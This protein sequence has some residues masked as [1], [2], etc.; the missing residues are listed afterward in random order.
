MSSL[1]HS[2][3]LACLF[4]LLCCASNS[5]SA[6]I[7]IVDAAGSG[8]FLDLPPALLVVQPGDL[9][10]VE[11]GDYSGGL[12]PCAITLRGRGA[13]TRIRGALRA[14]GLSGSGILLI[15]SLTLA[16]VPQRS[17]QI[18]AQACSIYSY[19]YEYPE[20]GLRFINCQTPIHVSEVHAETFPPDGHLNVAGGMSLFAQNCAELVLVSSTFRCL[21]GLGVSSTG[22][23]NPIYNLNPQPVVDAAQIERCRA[24]VDR[25][26]FEG[27]PGVRSSGYCN[28]WTLEFSSTPG[29]RGG[30]GLRIAASRVLLNASACYG[31][32]GADNHSIFGPYLCLTPC[33]RPTDGGNGV[34]ILDGIYRRTDLLAFA[35]A[36]RGGLGGR[37]INFDNCHPG[38][39]MGPG[40]RGSQLTGI[41]LSFRVERY[42]LPM[43][44][45]G[46]ALRTGSSS[47]LQVDAW[48]AG[49]VAVYL[50]TRWIPLQLVGTVGETLLDPATGVNFL[51]GVTHARGTISFALDRDPALIGTQLFFQAIQLDPRTGLVRLGPVIGDGVSG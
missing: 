14:E 47:S 3:R 4:A 1:M 15:T 34:S 39:P 36:A 31:G 33:E 37:N 22:F 6:R 19:Y 38:A 9:V 41:F 29:V 35:T 51:L 46:N 32:V 42:G 30:D 44:S 48:G 23:C 11:V 24:I 43:L 7:W 16:V 10:Q 13:A 49:A 45:L 28:P 2:L 17:V 27:A 18:S 21:G 50:G 25:C 12:I 40:R 8:D 20:G 5:L 26:V